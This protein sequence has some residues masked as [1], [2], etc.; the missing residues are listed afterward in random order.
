MKAVQERI[1]E[2]QKADE[3]A[4]K[5]TNNDKTEPVSFIICVIQ[6]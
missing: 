5:L 3:K 4:H 1:N 2:N 6:C